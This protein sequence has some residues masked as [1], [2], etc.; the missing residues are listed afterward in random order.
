M[1]GYHRAVVALGLYAALAQGQTVTTDLH[2]EGIARD[3]NNPQRVLYTEQHQL[4]LRDGKP[5]QRT[6]EYR[7]ASGRLLATKVNQYG[8]NPATPDFILRDARRPYTESAR[9]HG[10]SLTLTLQEG[11]N[12]SEQTL[13]GLPAALIVDAGFDEFVRQHWQRLQQGQRVTFYFASAARQDLIE[14]RLE[15]QRGNDQHLVL[16]MRLRSRLIAWLLDPIELTY[17][18]QSQRLLRYRGLTNMQDDNGTTLKADIEYR[19]SENRHTDL[20]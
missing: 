15:P 12:R 4:Q 13:T 7:D 5:L 11:D 14:F 6:V 10:D 2:Y 17:D 20:L 3:L 9:L 18:R 1:N 19:Y 16:E 8:D